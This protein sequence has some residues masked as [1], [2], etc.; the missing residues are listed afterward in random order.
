MVQFDQLRS[1]AW[2]AARVALKKEEN[3]FLAIHAHAEE[4]K[5]WKQ[6]LCPVPFL[7]VSGIIE[8]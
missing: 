5:M 6:V 1:G 8:A 3:H 4:L 2:Q 7:A